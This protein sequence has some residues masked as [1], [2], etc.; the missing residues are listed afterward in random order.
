MSLNTH[1]K[2]CLSNGKYTCIVEELIF[3]MEDATQVDN[4][5]SPNAADILTEDNKAG[6]SV[7]CCI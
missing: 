4:L 6:V 1:H 5:V 3:S 2:I 7:L